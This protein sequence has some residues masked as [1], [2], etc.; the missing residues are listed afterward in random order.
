MPLATFLCMIPDL[1]EI[2]MRRRQFNLTQADL[3][4]LAGVSQS[5]IA[6]LESDVVVPSYGNAKRIFDALEKLQEQH[7]VRAESVM[8][9]K[10]C[11][12]RDSD[13]AKKAV[14]LME[15]NAISQLPVLSESG[16][17]VGS[18]S[19]ENILKKISRENGNINLSETT[20]RE[21]M[22]NSFPSIQPDTPLRIV[23]SILEH[24]SAVIVAE[25]GK[26]KGIITKA[27]LL[28]AV[29]KRK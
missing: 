4:V 28:K 11:C 6:K 17:C 25:N 23:Q 22:D 14:S 8:Q 29:L 21:L 13:S 2:K 15:K 3:A 18:V 19:E 1:A 7:S 12:L 5:L 10:V 16:V 9:K 24:N 26:I 27:D 20:V